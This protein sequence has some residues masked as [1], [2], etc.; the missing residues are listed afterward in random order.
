MNRGG[1]GQAAQGE[2]RQRARAERDTVKLSL[3]T[4]AGRPNPPRTVSTT[5]FHFMG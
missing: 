1:L 5:R 3:L 2:F 4:E